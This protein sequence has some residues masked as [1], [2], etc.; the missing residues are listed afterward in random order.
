[1]KVSEIKNKLESLLSDLES[2][3][4][5]IKDFIYH[6]DT[7]INTIKNQLELINNNIETNV[8]K[9]EYKNSQDKN[10]YKYSEDKNYYDDESENDNM[11]DE[12]LEDNETILANLD[13]NLAKLLGMDVKESDY[14]T[15]WKPPNFSGLSNSE[16]II[17]K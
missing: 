8:S 4:K 9:N 5:D 1:M 15:D 12:E 11:E 17:R 2:K 3:K 7:K 16:R 13:P 6:I 14:I 10:E